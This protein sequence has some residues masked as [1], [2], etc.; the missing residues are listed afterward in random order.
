MSQRI[1]VIE[2]EWP[3]EG[4]TWS[5]RRVS[6]CSC[7]RWLTSSS[8]SKSLASTV[9]KRESTSNS[10]L[11]LRSSSFIS[12]VCARAKGPFSVWPKYHRKV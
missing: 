11:D 6:S 7:S 9:V 8:S 3:L 1:V 4:G 12:S 5:A 10:K 2:K